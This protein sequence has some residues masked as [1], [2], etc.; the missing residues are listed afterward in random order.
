MPTENTNISDHSIP[1]NEVSE[2]F[3]LRS[4]PS[5]AIE[6][7][8][9]AVENVKSVADRDIVAVAPVSMATGYKLSQMPFTVVK[10]DLLPDLDLRAV[11][12]YELLIIGHPRER[13]NHSL[14]E[15]I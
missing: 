13:L 15:Y 10:L 14:T 5:E 1:Y 4:L 6:R 8:T 7:D 3:P 2:L 9:A 11:D 12:E